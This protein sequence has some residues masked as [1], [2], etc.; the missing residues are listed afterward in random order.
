MST[1]EQEIELFTN[2]FNY[3]FDYEDDFKKPLDDFSDFDTF[4]PDF[5]FDSIFK[6]KNLNQLRISIFSIDFEIQSLLEELFS[7]KEKFETSKDILKTRK[8]KRDD[9]ESY[10]IKELFDYDNKAKK[11]FYVKLIF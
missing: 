2:I 5:E 11:I 9:F 10:M 6:S 4:P 3:P 7:I 8:R 1:F